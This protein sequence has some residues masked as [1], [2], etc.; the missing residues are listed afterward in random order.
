MLGDHYNQ[1][2]YNVH[3]LDRLTSGLVILAK[4]SSIAQTW[5]N[6][7]KDRD[8]Q[9]I[10]LARIKGRFP[11][12]CPKDLR[13]I[14]TGS[15]PDHGEW[16]NHETDPNES[17]QPSWSSSV[18]I[19]LRRKQ[20]ARAYWIMDGTGDLVTEESQGIRQVF[21]S[22]HSVDDWLQ[23]IN[24]NNIGECRNNDDGVSG[25]RKMLWFHIACPTRIAQPK[26]GVCEA[27]SFDVLDDKTYKKTVKP[28][29]SSFGVVSY[30]E[31]SDS[32]VVVSLMN[33]RICFAAAS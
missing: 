15:L 24:T 28:A 18:D 2:I 16:Q 33:C 8:C 20:Y 11:L 6:C 13:R 22:Q 10:Y 17:K 32:T 12:S 7:I 14:N 3:R 29:E 1:K 9:K 30:D 21:E 27:G 19:P 4:N 25:Q 31:K 26:I 23:S 5:G